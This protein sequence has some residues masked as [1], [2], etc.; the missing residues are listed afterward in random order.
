MLVHSIIIFTAVRVPEFEIT[1]CFALRSP[2]I[3][4]TAA[5]NHTRLS[6]RYVAHSPVRIAHCSY[7]SGLKNQH[8]VCPKV[9]HCPQNIRKAFIC[10]IIKEMKTRQ[11]YEKYTRNS[12]IMCSSRS[13][14]SYDGSLLGGSSFSPRRRSRV[15]RLPTFWKFLFIF[16][17]LFCGVLFVQIVN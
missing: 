5:P 8:Q 6:H 11:V 16:V 10:T 7:V 4:A 1:I 3:T 14:S 12:K 17:L 15:Q 2:A 9:R 13:A